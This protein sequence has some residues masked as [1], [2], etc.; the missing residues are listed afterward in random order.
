MLAPALAGV[1]FHALIATSPPGCAG[2]CNQAQPVPG[3]CI[4]GECP[5][6]GTLVDWGAHQPS[7]LRLNTFTRHRSLISISTD[8]DLTAGVY[9][10][11]QLLRELRI[12]QGHGGKKCSNPAVRGILIDAVMPRNYNVEVWN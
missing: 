3:Q 10:N 7:G 6:S 4:A 2:G 8:G 9:L 1:T 12:R 11:S 5:E